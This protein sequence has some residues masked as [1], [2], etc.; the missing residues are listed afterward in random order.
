MVAIT[1]IW[2][3]QYL[4]TYSVSKYDMH[5]GAEKQDLIWYSLNWIFWD[6]QLGGKYDIIKIMKRS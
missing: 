4:H 5:V 1:S 2:R 6:D 3:D